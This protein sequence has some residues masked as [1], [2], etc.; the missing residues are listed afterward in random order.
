MKTT[1]RSSNTMY[2]ACS[3]PMD[4]FNDEMV[5]VVLHMASDVVNYGCHPIFVTTYP[6][7]PAENPK[8]LVESE[9]SFR[10]N[11]SVPDIEE[12]VLP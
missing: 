9:T 10:A 3:L 11:K 6:Q 4:I 2:H 7:V 8:P 1:L 12:E 5:N